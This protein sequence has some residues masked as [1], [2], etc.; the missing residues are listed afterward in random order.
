MFDIGFWELS[1]IGIVALLVIGPERLPSVA[2]TVGK[3][4]GRAN[5]F[6]SNV[7]DDISKELKDEDLK[8]ILADQQKLADE[9]KKA[10]SD[11][12]SAISSETDSM[13]GSVSMDDILEIEEN[14]N[15]SSS[16]N[17]GTN[18]NTIGKPENPLTNDTSD[19][20]PQESTSKESTPS[21]KV[22]ANT[23]KS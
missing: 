20:T 18:S 21:T 1:L 8:K 2:R 15:K 13:R 7:K 12:N 19:S 10:A 11:M 23:E 17:S 6:V 14:D 5:R 4:V 3:Y 16:S 9:Y 22:Q